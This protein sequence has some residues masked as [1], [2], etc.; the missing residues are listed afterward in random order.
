MTRV[1]VLMRAFMFCLSEFELVEELFL[2]H[3][4]IGSF[5]DTCGYSSDHVTSF[6]LFK[7]ELWLIAKYITK[8]SIHVKFLLRQYLFYIILLKSPIISLR[9]ILID[10]QMLSMRVE[11]VSKIKTITT[12]YVYF[13]AFQN[14]LQRRLLLS[15]ASKIFS[16]SFLLELT[17]IHIEARSKLPTLVLQQLPQ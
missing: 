9:T 8:T 1:G 2:E 13:T 14:L 3:S 17:A 7:L 11:I 4:E 10:V 5:V 6:H 12:T 16:V 15:P